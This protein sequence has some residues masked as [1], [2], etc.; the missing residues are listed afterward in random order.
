MMAKADAMCSE[1]SRPTCTRPYQNVG[2]AS[3]SPSSRTSGSLNDSYRAQVRRASS[4]S[5]RRRGSAARGQRQP[6]A[7]GAKKPVKKNWIHGRIHGAPA[8][9]HRALPRDQVQRHLRP[10]R[11]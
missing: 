10:R 3:P 6:A 8:A 4:H 7:G 11:G 9:G 1:R 2:A 5:H